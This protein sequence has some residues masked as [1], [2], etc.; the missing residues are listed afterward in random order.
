MGGDE[1]EKRS[2]CSGWKQGTRVEQPLLRAGRVKERG[3]VL[4]VDDWRL[5]S[6]KGLFYDSFPPSP[7][8]WRVLGKGRVQA[9]FLHCHQRHLEE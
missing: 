7:V 6:I 5:L 3:G 9:R 1:R 8:N 4:G 2:S